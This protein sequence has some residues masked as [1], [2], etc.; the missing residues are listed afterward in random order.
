MTE[1]TSKEL[2]PVLHNVPLE[3]CCVDGVLY[4]SKDTFCKKECVWYIK[5]EVNTRI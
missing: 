3:L 2:E 5:Y 1:S 4:N